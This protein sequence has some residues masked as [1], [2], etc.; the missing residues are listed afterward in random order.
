MSLVAPTAALTV[1]MSAL[2]ARAALRE[3]LTLAGYI[4]S[5]LICIGAM[6][7]V[8]FGSREEADHTVD[9]MLALFQES[10]SPYQF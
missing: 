5:S 7:A 1:P 9:E 3:K 10:V 2:L 8:Y 6:G 4:G